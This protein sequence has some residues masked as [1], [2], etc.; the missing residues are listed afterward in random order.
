MNE[1]INKF[2]EIS[3]SFLEQT[4]PITGTHY[5]KMFKLMKSLNNIAPINIFIRNVL[6]HK[7][8]IIARNEMYF[9]EQS[10]NNNNN[11]IIGISK[12]YHILDDES[13]NNVWDIITALVLLAEQKH[14]SSIKCC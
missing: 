3:L 4:A 7:Q 5:I 6:P 14:I 9:T 10:R 13:K 1:T 11:D 8:K 2:N 12:I